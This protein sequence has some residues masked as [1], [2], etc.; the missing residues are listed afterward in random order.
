MRVTCQHIADFVKTLEI[1]NER[2][3]GESILN[4]VIW[5]NRVD[6]EDSPHRTEVLYQ[7][8][9]IVVCSSDG[10]QY[11]LEVGENCGFDRT[12]GEPDLE[13]SKRHGELA[14]QV[15]EACSRFGYRRRPG[16]V[17]F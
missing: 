7:L 2:N 9:A 12:D 4:R 15:E 6:M 11:L 17:G 3:S 5:E 13:G 1:I 14:Q 16:I 10:G 8:S